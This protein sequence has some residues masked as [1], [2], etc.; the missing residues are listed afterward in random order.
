MCCFLIH[1]RDLQFCHLFEVVKRKDII[2]LS[3]LWTVFGWTEFPF[4]SRQRKWKKKKKKKR[5][6]LL[7][8]LVD[9]HHRTCTYCFYLQVNV[10]IPCKQ[11]RYP[12]C[13]FPMTFFVPGLLLTPYFFLLLAGVLYIQTYLHACRAIDVGVCIFLVFHGLCS[14]STCWSLHTQM[15][16]VM[17]ISERRPSIC[18]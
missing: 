4:W 5:N 1:I 11:W 18:N 10:F 7:V 15:M 2:W 12:I 8:M 17:A 6:S 9:E 16:N 14:L 3:W 13:V